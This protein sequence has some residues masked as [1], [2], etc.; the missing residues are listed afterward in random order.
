MKTD[1]QRQTISSEQT[2]YCP[3]EE[4]EVLLLDEKF[5][6]N[7]KIFS[8]PFASFAVAERIMKST[9][10]DN[11]K[12]LHLSDDTESPWEQEMKSSRMLRKIYK[13]DCI[14]RHIQTSCENLDKKLDKL[15]R[16][17]LIIV[18]E[19]VNLNLFLLT[20]RQEYIILK[21][22]EIMETVLHNQVNRKLEEAA[23]V[24]QKVS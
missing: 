18:A 14:L 8:E 17:R 1:K 16:D 9:V 6:E 20:L 3:D 11:I 24:K 21:E 7:T 5:L 23:A 12:L 13:Q 22:Y 10:Q 19:N 4:Y 15:E 2:F